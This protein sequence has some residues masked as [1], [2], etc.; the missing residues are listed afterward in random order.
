MSQKSKGMVNSKKSRRVNLDNPNEKTKMCTIVSLLKY[1][2]MKALFELLE[3]LLRF[4]MSW[5]I[6]MAI[7]FGMRLLIVVFSAIFG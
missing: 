1:N 2:Y 6:T 3:A 5:G 7:T 4:V